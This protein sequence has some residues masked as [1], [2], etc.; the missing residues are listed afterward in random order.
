MGRRG[1]TAALA[2]SLLP[3]LNSALPYVARLGVFA[4]CAREDDGLTTVRFI[5]RPEGGD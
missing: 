4:A 2:A 5:L 1:R 3:D